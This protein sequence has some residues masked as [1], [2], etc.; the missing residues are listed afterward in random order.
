MIAGASEGSAAQP[1]GRLSAEEV[2]RRIDEGKRLMLAKEHAAAVDL[3]QALLRTDPNRPAFLHWLHDALSAAGRFDEALGPI[4]RAATANP[5]DG[6]AWRKIAL[7]HLRMSRESKAVR[8]ARA[9]LERTPGDS[10][11]VEIMLQAMAKRRRMKPALALLD[12]VDPKSASP[13]LAALKADLLLTLGDFEG[14]TLFLKE[15][16][17]HVAITPR[18]LQTEMMMHAAMGDADAALEAGRVFAARDSGSGARRQQFGVRLFKQGLYEEALEEFDAALRLDHSSLVALSYRYE[19]LAKLGRRTEARGAAMQLAKTAPDNERAMLRLS[20]AQL[21]AG[22]MADAERSMR[23]S[24]AIRKRRLPDSLQHGLAKLRDSPEAALSSDRL[25][26]AWRNFASPGTGRS[27]WERAVRFGAA[28]DNLIQDWLLG[29]PDRADELDAVLH[30][31]DEAAIRSL[32]GR[33][34]GALLVGAH[35]GA[36]FAGL[37][38]VR[39]QL[40]RTAYLFD[41]PASVFMDPVSMIDK[42]ASF[43]LRRV[44]RLLDSGVSVGL[45]GDTVH[46]TNTATARLPDGTRVRV[47]RRTPRLIW[48]HQ[49]VSI[50]L[51]S[52]WEN[53]RVRIHLDPDTPFPKDGEPYPDWEAR[54][55]RAYFDKV[56]AALRTGPENLRLSG[57]FWDNI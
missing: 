38:F 50:F 31:L 13:D 21:A 57:G 12:R 23:E 7:L 53:D 28:A 41:G 55:L 3:F 33:N 32:Q 37:H 46:S 27:G 34:R 11:L 2:K 44:L 48:K 35:I 43:G 16:R 6:A 45:A 51:F 24:L 5:N 20:R 4:E 9:S 19:C 17:R 25:G 14:L 30:P 49:I 52:L 22:E 47:S 40:S 36:M 18:L 39:T 56:F 1:E 10:K 54:W 26:W 42:D 15:T 8:V 29:A